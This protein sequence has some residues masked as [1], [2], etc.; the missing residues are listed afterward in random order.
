MRPPLH[1]E[2]GVKTVAVAHVDQVQSDVEFADV[3]A[4]HHAEALRLA[5]LLCG[6]RGRAEDAVA[7][8][9]VKIYRQMLRRE[10]RQPRAYIRRAV[11][12]QINS[13]FR[14]L[15]LERREAAKRSGDDRGRRGPDEELVDHDEMFAALRALPQ[16]QRT[17]VV[18]RYYSDLPEK[19]IAEV[20]GVSVG[21]VKSSLH[22]GLE[23]LRAELGEE[24]A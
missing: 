8:A 11:V 24:V 1:E 13:G 14:R 18:L 15:A 17:V 12:N 22:R 20:M 23:R 3:Y 21:T 10:I 2:V 4:A 7:D 9:F 5:Y 19:Q 6:D 16:R